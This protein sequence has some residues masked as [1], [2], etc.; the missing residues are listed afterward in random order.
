M[1]LDAAALG[2]I[3]LG[4]QRPSTLAAAGLIDEL[5]PGTLARADQL[6]GAEATPWCPTGF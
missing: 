5:R 6:F 3:Y 2:A 4:G 1:A